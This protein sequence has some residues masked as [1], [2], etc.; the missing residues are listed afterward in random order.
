MNCIPKQIFFV[1]MGYQPVG[2][3]VAYDESNAARCDFT[4]GYATYTVTYNANGTFSAA[5]GP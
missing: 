5:G 4:T 3:T 1:K 2:S